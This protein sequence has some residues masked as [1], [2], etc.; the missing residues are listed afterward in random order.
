V[1]GYLEKQFHDLSPGLSRNEPYFQVR[2]GS[3]KNPANLAREQVA[4]LVWDSGPMPARVGL[5]DIGFRC[6]KDP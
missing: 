3:F 4:D 1:F 2:G 5:D 6:V